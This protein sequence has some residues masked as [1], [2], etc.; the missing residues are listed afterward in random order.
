MARQG[1]TC[2]QFKLLRKLK[3]EA[4]SEFGA[5]LGS[6]AKPYLFEK[7]KWGVHPATT[8]SCECVCVYVYI[9]VIAIK[10]LV[11]VG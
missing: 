5:S 9:Y 4:H 6:T 3:Q 8:A 11:F 7:T 1:G 10:G 2:L